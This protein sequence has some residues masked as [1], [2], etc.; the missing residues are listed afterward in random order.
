MVALVLPG[1]RFSR[2]KREKERAQEAMAWEVTKMII[3]GVKQEV[4]SNSQPIPEIMEP[5]TSTTS[6]DSLLVTKL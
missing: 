5:T 3:A 6:N 2:K 4:S 1:G